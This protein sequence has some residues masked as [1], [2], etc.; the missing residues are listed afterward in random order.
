[1]GRD[2]KRQRI[3]RRESSRCSSS[4]FLKDVITALLRVSKRAHGSGSGSGNRNGNGNGNSNGSGSGSG[5]GPRPARKT[6]DRLLG[7]CWGL[8]H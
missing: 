1:M 6:L 7:L 8:S 2:P 4:L 3:G 5:T